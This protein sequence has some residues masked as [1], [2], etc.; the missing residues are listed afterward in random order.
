M[1]S[2]RSCI[3]NNLIKSNYIT[4]L[5]LVMQIALNEYSHELM[6]CKTY[7]LLKAILPVTEFA[8]QPLRRD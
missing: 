3:K 4:R 7:I 6:Y 5:F 8:L 2:K 1:K